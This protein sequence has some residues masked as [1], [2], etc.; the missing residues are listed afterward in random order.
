[1]RKYKR[2]ILIV[3]AV[4]LI[5]AAFFGGKYLLDLKYYKEV[6][7]TVQIGAVSFSELKDGT[8][9][10]SFDAKIVSATVEVVIKDG[11]MTDVTLLKHKF[12][13]GKPAE[14]ILD[15]V[16]E[17]QSLQVDV[18]SGATQSS[19]TILKAIENACI[20]K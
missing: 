13:R 7:P 15:K 5:V 1:M 6:M 9:T 3:I 19:K 14:A 16:L 2:I 20:N 11:M 17:N 12:E 8:Y 18:V 4:V 10:G